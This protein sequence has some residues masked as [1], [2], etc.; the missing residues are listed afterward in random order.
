[1]TVSLPECDLDGDTL[2][3]EPTF[4]AAQAA[5]STTLIRLQRGGETE[6]FSDGV[7]IRVADATEVAASGLGTALAV[8]I[9]EDPLFAAFPVSASVYLNATCSET[10]AASIVAT[11]GT[12]TFQALY[13]PEHDGDDRL[14]EGQLALIL[15]DPEQPDVVHGSADGWFRFFYARGRPAQTFP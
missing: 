13:A 3:L 10:G 1:M 7:I 15:G 8:G 9:S 14:I 5:E 12:V 2:D 6:R 4:F 11:G